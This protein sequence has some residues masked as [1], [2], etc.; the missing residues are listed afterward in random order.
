MRVDGKGQAAVSLGSEP[1]R[2]EAQFSGQVTRRWHS[3]ALSAL[4]L[5]QQRLPTHHL[6]PRCPSSLTISSLGLVSPPDAP[7][8]TQVQH[9]PAHPGPEQ[10][11]TVSAL[12][13][14]PA[15]V[16]EAVL[17]YRVNGRGQIALPMAV[18]GQRYYATVPSLENRDQLEYWIV[19]RDASGNV[20][21]TP[22]TSVWIGGRGREIVVH[23]GPA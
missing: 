11:I 17:L 23:A 5:P 7:S 19:A 12:V 21:T 8:I 15:G 18:Q 6:P 10:P 2:L 9:F 13:Y 16:A 20:H 22:V 4:R 3:A 1:G 14:A